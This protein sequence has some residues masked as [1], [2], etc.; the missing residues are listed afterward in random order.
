LRGLTFHDTLRGILLAFFPWGPAYLF[1]RATFWFGQNNIVFWYYQF[2]GLRLEADVVS[3]ALGG[4]LVSYLLRP[5]W[6]VIQV[7]LNAALIYVLFYLACPT[8]MAGPIWRSECY[9]LGPDGLTGVRLC[10]MMFSF[11]AISALVRASY[12]E[13]RLNKRLRPWI[14]ILGAFIT[15]VVTAWFPLAEWFSGVTYL[16]P[17][18]PFQVA[19]LFGVTEIAV[20]IHAAKISRSILIAAISGVTSALLLSGFL[21]PILCPSCD[22][23]LL[24]LV[25]PS[26]GFFALIGGILELGLPRKLSVGL[27]RHFNPRLVEIHRIGIA[28][29]LFFS[30]WTL[31]AFEFRD[32]SVLYPT[33]ISPAPGQLTLGVPTYPYVGGY[34]N[35][36]DQKVCCVQIGVS[37]TKVDLKALTSNNFLM[38][39]MGF[40]SP[41]CCI[42]GW[43]FGWRADL[44]LLPN[45]TR[46]VSGSTWETCEGNAAC[47]GFIWEHIRYHAQQIINTNN[48]ST[49][50]Y[51]RMM[52][53][54]E[55]KNWHANWY[56]NYTGRSWTKFGSFVPDFREAPYFNIG[57]TGAGNY[58]YPLA[59]FYQFGVATKT[60]VPG[61]SVQLLYPSFINPR[62]SWSLVEKANTIQGWHS[63]WK[64]NYRWGGEPYNGVS[65][66]ANENER[67]IPVGILQ[68]TYTGTGSLPE[69]TLLC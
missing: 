33:N 1:E 32:A 58:P 47:G 39:G 8:Y 51:L 17:L 66:Q 50:V 64:G 62:G 49:P 43:D 16:A 68:L 53:Q 38:A 42:D 2:S 7:F 20:G 37:F 46:I 63:F 35:S 45:G 65:A 18:V 31:V 67:T 22:R 15:S 69:N 61:W 11:G 36:T 24:F 14:A 54:Y 41:N 56:Y 57:V 25:V 60:P 48:I 27:L 40:Q 23:T 5:R 10:T 13:D 28:V 34:Y 4:I 26:W 19:L 6:A 55:Q 30:L 9:A 52:W 59:F 21:W 29:V 44:F 12:K 3:F